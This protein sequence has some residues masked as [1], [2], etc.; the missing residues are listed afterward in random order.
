MATLFFDLQLQL[1]RE[2]G[3]QY[4]EK[5]VLFAH[6][7]S[8]NLCVGF[9]GSMH[10][11]L[12]QDWAW[13]MGRHYWNWSQFSPLGF[14]SKFHSF[15]EFQNSGIVTSDRFCQS[16]CCAVENTDFLFFLLCQLCRILFLIILFYIVFRFAYSKIDLGSIHLYVITANIWR[17]NISIT[18]SI[19][20][21]NLFVATPYPH[22]YPLTITDLF[23]L[24]VVLC[25]RGWHMV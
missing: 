8:C 6:L 5:W 10:S 7:V 4:F 22:L 9:Q 17:Q 13:K 24:T 19:L 12:P 21:W 23:P 11:C 25:F 20:S 2:P 16:I 14:I 18:I 15:N 1:G 3:P